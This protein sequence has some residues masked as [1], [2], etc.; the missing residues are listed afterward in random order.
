MMVHLHPW[1]T[2]A[3]DRVTPRSFWCPVQ[4]A[5]V[6]SLVTGVITTSSLKIME[7]FKVISFTFS[8]KYKQLCWP[9]DKPVMFSTYKLFLFVCLFWQFGPTQRDYLGFPVL[10]GITDSTKQVYHFTVKKLRFVSLINLRFVHKSHCTECPEK[11][12]KTPTPHTTKPQHGTWILLFW[13]SL[14]WLQTNT[15]GCRLL[16]E[17]SGGMLFL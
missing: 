9:E 6:F 11:K 14:S 12:K 4:P 10:S 2:W 13:S 15:A 5:S 16:W 1:Y 7:T 3:G 8:F 17:R